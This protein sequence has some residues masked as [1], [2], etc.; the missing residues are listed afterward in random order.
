MHICVEEDS[1]VDITYLQIAKNRQLGGFLNNGGEI[2][3]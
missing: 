1:L 2:G 3:I